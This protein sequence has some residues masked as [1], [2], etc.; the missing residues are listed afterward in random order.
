LLATRTSRQTA[1]K[2]VDT[3][4]ATSAAWPSIELSPGAR[5]E[6]RLGLGSV[7]LMLVTDAPLSSAA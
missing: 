7:R 2:T 5:D 3:A 4:L 1:Q 6:Q